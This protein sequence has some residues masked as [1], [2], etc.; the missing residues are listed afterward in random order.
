[1]NEK[2]NFTISLPDTFPNKQFVISGTSLQEAIS[3]DFPTIDVE[4]ILGIPM[5][6]RFIIEHD[7][8]RYHVV[9]V[10]EVTYSVSDV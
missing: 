8:K 2:Q 10:N 5:P 3:K 4:S 7:N 6:R 1:M 9:K